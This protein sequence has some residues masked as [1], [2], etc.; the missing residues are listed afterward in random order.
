MEKKDHRSKMQRA[1]DLKEQ[2]IKYWDKAGIC[3]FDSSTC[4]GD[5]YLASCDNFIESC[6]LEEL[7]EKECPKDALGVDIGAGLGR[8]TVVLARHLYLVHSL[9]AAKNIYYKLADNCAEFS[10]VKIFDTDFESFNTKEKYD[11]AVVSGL[12]YLYPDNMVHEFFKKLISH[13]KLGGFVI[14]RDFIVENGVKQLP[15]AYI[16]G[17]FCYY[18]NLK[19]WDDLAQEYGLMLSGIFQSKPSYSFR[20]LLWLCSKLGLTR[21]FSMNNVKKMLYRT[22]KIKK[23]IGIIDFSSEIQ[24]VFIVMRKE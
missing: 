11:I 23:K 9:E 14:I 21:I 8:F 12:L 3:S 17:G 5:P 18:R 1:Q 16:E 7:I 4:T 15:S 13:L 24:T 19:Y 6:L 22:V 10:N 2:I 20:R